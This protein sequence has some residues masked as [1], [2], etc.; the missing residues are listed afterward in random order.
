MTVY[1]TILKRRSIR[2]FKQKPIALSILK[3]LVDAARYAPSAANLQPW[4]FVIVNK[5]DVV[6]ELFGFSQWAGYLGKKGAPQAGQLP[7]SFIVALL[8]SE[9]CLKPK[10]A[11]ADLGAVVQNILLTATELGLGSCWL[12]AI[13]RVGIA[14]L[15]NA[16]K[17]VSVEYAVALGFPDEKSIA[18]EMKRSHKYYRDK[19]GMLHVPKRPLAKIIHLNKY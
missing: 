4:E 3:K 14:K 11:Q 16:P 19:K 5:K 9:R 2:R 13:D 1:K 10:Y 15:L 17:N 8:N 18:E 6:D 12:G 7:V